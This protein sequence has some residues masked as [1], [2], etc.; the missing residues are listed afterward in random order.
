MMDSQ[1]SDAA[2]EHE[3]RYQ[4]FAVP[5]SPLHNDIILDGLNLPSLQ[6]SLW[7]YSPSLSY[8]QVARSQSVWPSAES[9]HPAINR[10]SFN[11]PRYQQR[12]G[13]EA[14][15][16]QD[17]GRWYHW[18]QPNSSTA[19]FDDAV[20]SSFRTAN[21]SDTVCDTLQSNNISVTLNSSPT[22]HMWCRPSP[23]NTVINTSPN[24]F[25]ASSDAELIPKSDNAEHCRY[26][27]QRVKTVPAHHQ[28][29]VCSESSCD[30]L[31]S[32]SV[33]EPSLLKSELAAAGCVSSCS[34]SQEMSPITCKLHSLH[35]TSPC[36]AEE[37]KRECCCDMRDAAAARLHHELHAPHQQFTKCHK[38]DFTSYVVSSQ[39]TESC[40]QSAAM[41]ELDDIDIPPHNAAT[42]NSV[43]A[44]PAADTIS[45]DTTSPHDV[46]CDASTKHDSALRTRERGN[47]IADDSEL[48]CQASANIKEK[49]SKLNVENSVEDDASMTLS[50]HCPKQSLS[51]RK[52]KKKAQ[53]AAGEKLPP[54]VSKESVCDNNVAAFDGAIDSN[55]YG[56]SSDHTH[57]TNHT[58]VVSDEGVAKN[59]NGKKVLHKENRKCE[60]V[61]ASCTT[62]EQTEPSHTEA[63]ETEK[64]SRASA[65]QLHGESY[66][67]PE[68]PSSLRHHRRSVHKPS[69]AAKKSMKHSDREQDWTPTRFHLKR[70]LESIDWQQQHQNIGLFFNCLFN[71]AYLLLS[72]YC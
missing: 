36:L 54:A 26:S 21:N 16:H 8:Q 3:Q 57:R 6:S 58:G 44:E 70:F 28:A 24:D 40:R 50:S 66:L 17:T 31:D 23:L 41:N 37:M 64:L 7:S 38:T 53:R 33:D 49:R 43:P 13:N 30:T 61:G 9:S 32:C 12:P 18:Q 11:E 60:S 1:L 48:S 15:R 20:G 62:A 35:C 56:R 65:G 52:S 51:S 71:A 5:V 22:R 14:S 72:V 25:V 2:V 42:L 27:C 68:M 59:R 69:R 34:Y 39:Q 10:A 55:M 46:G 29:T 63:A 19:F 4:Q 47:V 67:K 45:A